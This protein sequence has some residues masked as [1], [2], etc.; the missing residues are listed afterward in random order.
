LF[1]DGASVNSFG[2]MEITGSDY[3]PFLHVLSIKEI[4]IRHG[5]AAL[6]LCCGESNLE[7]YFLHGNGSLIRKAWNSKPVIGCLYPFL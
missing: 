4:V 7:Q 1:H 2:G 6:G 3:R 5:K